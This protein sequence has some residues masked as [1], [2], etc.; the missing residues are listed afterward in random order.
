M[1]EEDEEEE[2]ECGC[3]LGFP[4]SRNGKRGKGEIVDQKKNQPQ[5]AAV[6]LLSHN[7]G[8]VPFVGEQPDMEKGE[9]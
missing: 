2:E 5:H 4:V 1:S 3:I 8:P 9:S 6:L 7:K